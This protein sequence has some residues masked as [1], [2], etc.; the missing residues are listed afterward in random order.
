MFAKQKNWAAV[1]EIL[2]IASLVHDDVLGFT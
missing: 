1:I 2:H